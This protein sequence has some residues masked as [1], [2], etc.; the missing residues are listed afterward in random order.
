MRIRARTRSP[1]CRLSL[2]HVMV[3]GLLA[4][5]MVAATGCVRN[6]AEDGVRKSLPKI[7]GP[8]DRY[9]VKIE[10]TADGRIMAGDIE[11]LTVVG[12]RVKTKGGL[13]IQRLQVKM[14]GL[15]IDTGKKQVKRV[16]SAVFDLDILQEDL[17][18]AARDRFHRIAN[19]V[20]LLGT[21]LVIVS[22]P[23]RVLKASLD[24]TLR[25][26]LAVESGERVNF[27]PDKLTIG[28]LRIP[29]HLVT[30][31]VAQLNPVADMRDLPVPAQID[32]LT[33]DTGVMNVKGKLF[34]PA[35]TGASPR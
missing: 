11:D 22:L 1:H 30:A 23:A 3:L 9:D 31:A 25:G 10:N 14:H 32:S 16:D 2:R 24:A 6:M 34:V 35:D 13:I 17:T 8:A 19:P 33:S 7:I 12:W 27:V 28:I 20:V 21:N 18:L 29:E 26:T 5:S 15:K 4:T